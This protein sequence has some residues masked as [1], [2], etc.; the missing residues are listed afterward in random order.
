MKS[1]RQILKMGDEWCTVILKTSEANTQKQNV[2][3]G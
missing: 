2:G 3:V 1:S